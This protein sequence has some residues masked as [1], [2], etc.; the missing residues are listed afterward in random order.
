MTYSGLF[1]P[2]SGSTK[3]CLRHIESD[4]MHATSIGGRPRSVCLAILIAEYRYQPSVAGIKIQM[5][6]RC[7]IKIWLF[8][9]ERHAQHPFPEV[10]RSLSIR[11]H[12]CDVVNALSLNKCHVSLQLP[13]SL[14]YHHCGSESINAVGFQVKRS[15]F[16]SG[17]CKIR[18]A[19]TNLLPV[20]RF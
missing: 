12:Q 9:D 1:Q 2:L 3:A 4:V 16:E 15:L 8:K 17:F 19:F 5:V 6:F 14:S 7:I 11:T 20:D 10:D 18:Q 13:E